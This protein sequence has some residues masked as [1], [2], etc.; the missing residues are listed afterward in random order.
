[1]SYNAGSYSS[2]ARQLAGQPPFAVSSTDIGTLNDPLSLADPFADASPS[3]V[4]NNYGINKD[5]QLG[6]V[7]RARRMQSMINEVVTVL[8]EE[9]GAGQ[10]EIPLAELVELVST[11]IQALARERGVRYLTRLETDAV[12]PN[13]AANL[14]ALILANLAQNAVA[15]ARGGG[16]I[17]HV[18]VTAAHAGPLVSVRISDDDPGLPKPVRAKLFRPQTACAANCGGLG[19]AIAR[20]LAERNG[21]SLKLADA[22]K[23]T[24]FVLEL[25]GVRAITLEPGAAMP[26]LGGGA[27]NS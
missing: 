25:A 11:R 24:A 15:C 23:G 7:H 3:D 2:I 26:S 14:I 22:R 4:T 12:L 9:E 1:M 10:Y 21:A 13:R 17:S 5:Y 8:Q 18:T 20:E 16:A 19:I 6:L 27:R